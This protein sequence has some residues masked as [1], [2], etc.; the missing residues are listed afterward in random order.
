MKSI[1]YIVVPRGNTFNLE[2]SGTQVILAS[3][4]IHVGTCTFMYIVITAVM[5]ASIQY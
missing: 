4:S 5:I 2:L 1:V 3:S